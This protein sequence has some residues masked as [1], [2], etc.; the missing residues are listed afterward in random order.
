MVAVA[1]KKELSPFG[2][3]LR[4]LR[5]RAGLSQSGLART[6]NV[7]RQTYLRYERGETEP[8]F[9]VLCEL[10]GALGVSLDAFT[11][12]SPEGD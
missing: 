6:L 8:T 5:E 10:A 1:K 12:E 7:P 2:A 4:S 11:K 9:T 3:R